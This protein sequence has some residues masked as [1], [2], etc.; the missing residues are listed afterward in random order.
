MKIVSIKN[1]MIFLDNELI[2]YISYRKE[3]WII[4]II[5]SRF[6]IAHIEY[7]DRDD[8]INTLLSEIDSND[9]S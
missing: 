4:N 9:A 5:D 8:V 1:D 6:T 3:K 2:G 7:E